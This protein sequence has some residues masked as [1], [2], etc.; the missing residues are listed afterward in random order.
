M[1]CDLFNDIHLRSFNELILV[2]VAFVVFTISSKEI[3]GAHPFS[4]V[5]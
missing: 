3:I 2:K 1:V 4:V 5:S